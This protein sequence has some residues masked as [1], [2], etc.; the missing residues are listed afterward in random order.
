MNGKPVVETL[1]AF[2]VEN[3]FYLLSDKLYDFIFSKKSVLV[4]PKPKSA[5]F[6]GM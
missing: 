5:S 2:L 3:K 6:F 1:Q 4:Q